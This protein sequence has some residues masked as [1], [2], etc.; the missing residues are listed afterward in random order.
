MYFWGESPH[1]QEN[2]LT[3]EEVAKVAHEV[4]R[5]YCLSLGDASQPSWDAAPEWQRASCIAGVRHH[6]DYPD[7]T[8]EQSHEEWMRVKQADGWK[9]GPRKDVVRKEHPSFLPYAQLLATEKA[10]DYIFGAVVAQ[11]S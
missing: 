6:R 5:A 2:P 8:P 11:L 1:L 3:D 4:N 9:W 10:K 7:C